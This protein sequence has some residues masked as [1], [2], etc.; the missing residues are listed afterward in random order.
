MPGHR[1]YRFMAFFVLGLGAFLVAGSLIVPWSRWREQAVFRAIQNESRPAFWWPPAWRRDLQTGLILEGESKKGRD[2]T[3][4][5]V[6]DDGPILQAAIRQGRYSFH[7]RVIPA[8]TFRFRRVAPD[9][10]A[11]DWVGPLGLDPG[12]HRL[13]FGF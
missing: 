12:R 3:L 2:G 4:E 9:G 10:T 8:G 11:S 1:P 5:L 7:P 13:D 6:V